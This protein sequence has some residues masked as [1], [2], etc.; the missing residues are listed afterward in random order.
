MLAENVS[1]VSASRYLGH[2]SLRITLEIYAHLIPGS[3]DEVARV[4]SGGAISLD[5]DG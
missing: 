1:I 3:F 5:A 4:V 2:S